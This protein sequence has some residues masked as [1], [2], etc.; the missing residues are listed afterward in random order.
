MRKIELAMFISLLYLFSTCLCVNAAVEELQKIWSWSDTYLC[1]PR[2]SAN[3]DLIV[4]GGPQGV[5][6]FSR[7]GKMLWYSPTE[8]LVND[9][10]MSRDGSYIAALTIA[11]VYLF[12]SASNVPIWSF[13]PEALL[14]LLSISPD[15]QYIVVAGENLYVFSRF[16]NVP[17]VVIPGRFSSVS[18]SSDGYIVAGSGDKIFLFQVVSGTLWS[19]E[20][21]AWE[22]AREFKSV[23]ISPDGTFIAAASDRYVYL[24]TRVS[25]NPLLNRPIDYDIAPVF[26]VFL[27]DDGSCIGV[28]GEKGAYLYSRTGA[29]L[30]DWEI[31]GLRSVAFSPDCSYFAFGTEW[32][33]LALVRL[34]D[35]LRGEIFTYEKPASYARYVV[36][37]PSDGSYIASIADGNTL[38][39]LG[40]PKTPPRNLVLV[41]V[42]GVS[43][44]VVLG[45]VA[46][47]RKAS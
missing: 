37:I 23:A 5:Y 16:S 45:A 19:Y 31:T 15:G 2:V 7:A 25:N 3:G 10:C 29:R 6:L 1:G 21:P 14:R 24:F 39:V 34:D 18:V 30:G 9:I 4:V 44:V 12:S 20:I 47:K 22:G 8:S 40:K 33:P 13:S 43:T 46:W 35:R 28:A 27:S 32:P 36:S 38:I 42:V 41:A 17:L 11:R 26:S